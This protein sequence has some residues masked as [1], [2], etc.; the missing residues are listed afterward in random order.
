MTALA[1]PGIWVPNLNGTFNWKVSGD[2]SQDAL[3]GIQAFEKNAGD[4]GDATSLDVGVTNPGEIT[5][6]LTG[7]GAADREIY[8]VRRLDNLGLSNLRLAKSIGLYVDVNFAALGVVNSDTFSVLIGNEDWA[9]AVPT[10]WALCTMKYVGGSAD[11]RS[12]VSGMFNNTSTT[13]TSGAIP[14]WANA[15]TMWVRAHGGDVCGGFYEAAGPSVGTPARVESDQG[16]VRAGG[17][18]A[19]FM[20]FRI[21]ARAGAGVVSLTVSN[22]KVAVD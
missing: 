8:L 2:A 5:I 6:S 1:R 7:D 14:A 19:P 13:N 12:Q 15:G 4:V 9:S 3:S 22:I 18:N 21:A 20:I 17:V 16:W 11:R 10:E